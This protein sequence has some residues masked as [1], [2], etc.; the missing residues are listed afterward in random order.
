MS[1]KHKVFEPMTSVKG[2]SIFVNNQDVAGLVAHG[3]A[4]VE[5]GI[6]KARFSVGVASNCRKSVQEYVERKVG[7]GS[8]AT[9][10]PRRTY[11]DLASL[12]SFSGYRMSG[13]KP[14]HG[15]TFPLMQVL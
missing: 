5:A 10:P 7:L 4:N 1:I 15:G 12:G 13:V 9:S 14:V 3:N 2:N 11:R 6:V 8:L